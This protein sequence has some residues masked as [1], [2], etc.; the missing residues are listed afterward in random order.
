MAAL[1]WAALC[2]APRRCARA[3]GAL[4]PGMRASAPFHPPSIPPT[5]HPS[6][7]TFINKL[8]NTYI[9]TYIH[10]P[11][12]FSQTLSKRHGSKRHGHN[13]HH[14][15]AHT[16]AN[17]QEARVLSLQ[18]I[19]PSLPIIPQE[20]R[21]L[22][23]PIIPPSIS[24]IPL[25]LSLNLTI[26]PPQPKDLCLAALFHSAFTTEMFPFGLFHFSA[27][28]AVRQLIGTQSEETVFLYCTVSQVSSPSYTP[29][30]PKRSV[31]RW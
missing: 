19:P 3:G 9:H 8:I 30:A 25:F 6:I 26:I 23:L 12:P 15:R 10:P 24:I 27:R 13:A 18:I 5:I 20:A 31:G 29:I 28:H 4:G 11:F 22:S 21:V 1:T 16:H 7:E 2:Q 14:K 17:T